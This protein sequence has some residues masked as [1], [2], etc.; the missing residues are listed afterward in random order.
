MHVQID[1]ADSASTGRAAEVLKEAGISS[2]DVLLNNAGILRETWSK[3]DWDATF[4]T[5]VRGAPAPIA[6]TASA[7]DGNG[8]TV[9][10]GLLGRTR[11]PRN[12]R[13]R[14]SGARVCAAAASEGRWSDRECFFRAGSVVGAWRKPTAQG[15]A[16]PS[17]PAR[18]A[19][20][21]Q[22]PATCTAH[23]RVWDRLDLHS[24]RLLTRSGPAPSHAAAAP[25]GEHNLY[26]KYLRLISPPV[27]SLSSPFIFCLSRSRR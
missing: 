6:A 22:R 10:T 25:V 7:G 5:N 20:Y 17:P 26:S 14:P 15:A 13:R 9:V 1:M 24:G 4:A 19:S 21:W 23:H 8:I 11:S 12:R 3:A 18:S 27:F 2:L 16:G